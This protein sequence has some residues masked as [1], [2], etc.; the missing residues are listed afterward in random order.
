MLAAATRER[1]ADLD[2]DFAAL[3]VLTA[4][5]KWI[6]VALVYADA[7]TWSTPGI[8]S[9]QAGSSRIPATG[10]AAAAFGGYLRDLGMIEAGAT[11]TIR[12]G[13]RHGPTEPADRRHHR[14]PGDRRHGHGGRHLTAARTSATNASTSSGLV[15]HAVIQRTSPVVSFHT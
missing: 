6:T 11:F 8:R 10:A 5:E 1:L 12:P 15:S 13:R 2:Y 9:R 4:R 14:A 7:R 3:D